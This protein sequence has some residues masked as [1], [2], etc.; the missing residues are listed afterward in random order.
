MTGEALIVDDDPVSRAVLAHLVAKNG[1]DVHEAD[2]PEH[3]RELLDDDAF[4][5]VFSDYRMPDED[6]LTLFRSLSGRVPKPRFVLVSGVV[7][8]PSADPAELGVDAVLP[9][10]VMT[11]AVA[12][13]L[14][15]LGLPHA[16]P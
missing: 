3:A 8:L 1:Y 11:K 7:D 2:G 14:E 6:G 16:T 9:K 12:E 4:D 13:C 10:P 15:A 5:V